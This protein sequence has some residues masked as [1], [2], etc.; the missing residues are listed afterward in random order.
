MLAR[1]AQ[2]LLAS[3]GASRLHRTIVIVSESDDA[4]HLD[5]NGYTL[6]AS[7]TTGEIRIAHGAVSSIRDIAS[8]EVLR[9]ERGEDDPCYELRLRLTSGRAISFCKARDEVGV[10]IAAAHLARVCGKHVISDYS[11]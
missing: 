5:A 3:I 11:I 1:I 7:R 9:R 2:K 10:A 4:I 8:I 6:T